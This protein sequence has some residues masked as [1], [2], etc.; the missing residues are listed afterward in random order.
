MAERIGLV[1]LAVP[2]S[3]VLDTSIAFE[4]MS[5]FG[6]DLVEALTARVENR[7]PHFAEPLPW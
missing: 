6:P 7:P 2:P 1:S 3:D 5:V 4:A